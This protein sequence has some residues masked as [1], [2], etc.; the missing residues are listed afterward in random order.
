MQKKQLI[1]LISSIFLSGGMQGGFNLGSFVSE[2]KITSIF[3]AVGL[4]MTSF[5]VKNKYVDFALEKEN[6]KRRKELSLS[7]ENT[8]ETN[9][10]LTNLSK[11]I[12]SATFND[13]IQQT[14]DTK[15]SLENLN[16]STNN[17]QKTITTYLDTL[18]D[19]K[20]ETI[21]SRLME[22]FSICTKEDY[23]KCSDSEKQDKKD[24]L[25]NKINEINDD[26]DKQKQ[27]DDD[28]REKVI[29]MRIKREIPVIEEIKKI[30][31]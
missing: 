27:V 9:K 21:I 1:L 6:K 14:D 11:N 4:L 16:T 18:K 8:I 5:Y 23:I 7:Q 20:S 19:G 12:L 26:N 2:N 31:N 15:K 29:N 28:Y 30:K 10:Y 22:L 24:L 3:C 17:L 25:K 13:L